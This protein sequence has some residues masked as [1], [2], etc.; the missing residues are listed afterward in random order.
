M[1]T[2]GRGQPSVCVDKYNL[3]IYGSYIA[4]DCDPVLKP[5]D[6]SYLLK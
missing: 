4:N 5:V 3:G 2:D 1:I 6:L